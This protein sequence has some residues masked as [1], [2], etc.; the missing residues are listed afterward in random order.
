MKKKIIFI[1]LAALMFAACSKYPGY[2]KSDTGL[3][4]KFFTENE[5]AKKPEIGD[6]VTIEMTYKLK[7][8]VIFTSKDMEMPSRLQIVKPLYD[9]DI[10]EG[11]TMMGVG[12]SASFMISADSFFV[13]NVGLKELPKFIKKGDMLTFNVKLVSL[14]SK[15]EYQKEKALQLEKYNAMVEV[16]KSGETDSIKTYLLAN[17]YTVKPTATGMY[18]IETLKGAGTKATTGSTVTVNYTGKF[19][20][21]TVFD[22]SVGKDPISFVLGNKEVIPGWE[23]GIALMKK[24]GKAVFVIPSNLAYGP[25]GAGSLILPYTPLT[26]DVEL[27]DVTAT[28]AK[29]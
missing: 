3:Y 2:D 10:I 11:I 4:Y 6:V 20:N 19:L 27:V 9:G 14:Q 7:D 21:G 29:K 23:E 24:G 26:F 12:D 18:Y 15:E 8:S 17:K 1:A 22:S 5:N 25:N 28:A 16:R 13:K